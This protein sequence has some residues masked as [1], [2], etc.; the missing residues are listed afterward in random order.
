MRRLWT[1]RSS[2]PRD[3]KNAARLCRPRL[4][5]LDKKELPA[6][7]AVSVVADPNVLIPP[8]NTYRQIHVTG[9][10][11]DNR[12]IPPTANF[13]VVDLYRRHEPYGPLPLTP[14]STPN[15]YS[16][17]TSFF[18]RA[19]RAQH[20]KLG[21]LYYFI[22]ETGDQDGA[23]SRVIP[24]LVPRGKTAPKPPPPVKNKYSFTNRAG[25]LIVPNTHSNVNPFANLFAFLTPNRPGK[26]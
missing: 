24:I 2:K 12:P 18:L 15:Q 7:T 23:T 5:L 4:E 21:R 1:W 26:K 16:F 11:T 17:S 9:T 6:V 20:E 25:T 13:V 10:I 8:N 14:T 22:L 19:H 3:R